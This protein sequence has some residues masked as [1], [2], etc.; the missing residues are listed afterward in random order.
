M[1]ME[2]SIFKETQLNDDSYT[3]TVP[4]FEPLVR[5]N[6]HFLCD[7]KYYNW[8]ENNGL[9]L[10]GSSPVIMVRD[11]VAKM[12]EKAENLLTAQHPHMRLKIY[13]GYR[14]IIVQQ[15][16]YDHFYAIN[17]VNITERVSLPSYNILNPSLHNTGGSVDLT[18]VDKDENEL[19]MGC[20]F[21]FFDSSEAKIPIQFTNSFTERIDEYGKTV[22]HNRMLLRDIMTQ[23]GFV[24]LESE[25]W[26]YDYG[27]RNWAKTTGQNPMYAGILDAK[28]EGSI[29]YDEAYEICSIDTVQQNYAKNILFAR[30]ACIRV[31]NDYEERK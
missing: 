23:V 10:P 26:H 24:N 5:L 1:S 7:S 27:N 17:P 16:L 29:P 22:H 14:P 18:I 4:N 20:P 6:D 25:W 3:V 11:S 31:A 2:N 28:V 15:K 19:D 12:L 21:D 9:P 13:D 8:S 30:L